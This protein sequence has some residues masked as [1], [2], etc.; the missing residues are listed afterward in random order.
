MIEGT[1]NS[2]LEAVVTVAVTGTAERRRWVTAVIDTGYSGDITLPSA[3]V[4]GLDLASVGGTRVKL[5]DGAEA[6][7]ATYVA[8]VDWS[9]SERGVLVHETETTPLIG[10]ALLKGHRLQVDIEHGG[11]V[12]IEPLAS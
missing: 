2:A 8:T 5:A 12:R 1:V 6:R 9:E 4:S 7:L 11:S 10:M 3:I